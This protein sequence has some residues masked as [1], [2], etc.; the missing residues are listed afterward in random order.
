MGE[1]ED[2]LLCALLGC[3]DDWKLFRNKSSQYVWRG[4]DYLYAFMTEKDIQAKLVAE[5]SNLDSHNRCHIHVEVPI[6]GK[7]NK[8]G[9]RRSKPYNFRPDIFMLSTRRRERRKS[10]KETHLEVAAVEIKYFEKHH[11]PWMKWMIKR[12]ISKLRDCLTARVQPKADT[13]FF[14]CIDYTA[15]AGSILAKILSQRGMN[16]Q[17]IGYFVMVPRYVAERRDY[18]MNLEQYQQGLERSSVY[19]MDKALG[20]LK[21]DFSPAFDRETVKCDRDGK[22]KGTAGPWFYICVG[23][24]RIG[25]AYLDWKF[26]VGRTIRVGLVI[27][28]YDNRDHVGNPRLIEW[29][30]DS[31]AYRAS[32]EHNKD[33]VYLEKARS[34]QYDLK[35]M[36]ELADEIY[37]KV[38]KVVSKAQSRLESPS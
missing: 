17:H 26:R 4:R 9:R 24:K 11:K 15:K 1:N 31:E 33:R 22:W 19:V 12:D 23:N 2:W 7:T 21:R 28:P 37:R 16:R 29:N 36:N 35:K 8:R 6:Y 27:T 20:M 10:R 38:K 30:D 32:D 13:G 34:F 14:L 25:W 3:N 5:L 18:P